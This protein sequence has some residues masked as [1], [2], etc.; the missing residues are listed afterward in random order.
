MK[1]WI[2]KVQINPWSEKQELVSFLYFWY[3][4]KKKK[5]CIIL[6]FYLFYLVY[7]ILNFKEFILIIKVCFYFGYSYDME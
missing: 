3:K 5:N 4:S 6:V 2:F 1:D 7:E